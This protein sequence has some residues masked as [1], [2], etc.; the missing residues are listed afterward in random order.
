MKIRTGFVS[1]SS[2]SS[3]V[4]IGKRL[5]EDYIKEQ[6]FKDKKIFCNTEIYGT[7]GVYG[8]I[9]DYE[10]FVKLVGHSFDFYEVYKI[11]EEGEISIARDDIPE[12]GAEIIF[13]N[14]D[15]NFDVN[16]IVELAERDW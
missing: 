2:S 12:S 11:F 4:V 7:E 14:W 5:N 16:Y 1:N 15:Y 13:D 3:F 6:D 10:S 8:E 9:I